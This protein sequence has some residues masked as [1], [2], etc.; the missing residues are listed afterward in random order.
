MSEHLTGLRKSLDDIDAV[1]VSA[2][3]SERTCATMF[4]AELRVTWPSARRT[5]VESAKWK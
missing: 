4:Q 1:I 2:L 5:I 3:G